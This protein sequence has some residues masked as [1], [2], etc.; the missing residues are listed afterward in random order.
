LIHVV[1]D[2]ENY[3]TI[4]DDMHQIQMSADQL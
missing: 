2:V 3:C 1:N 4:K